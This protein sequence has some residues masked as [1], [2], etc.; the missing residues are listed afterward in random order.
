[1]AKQTKC[2]R[3]GLPKIVTAQY[4]LQDT[5]CEVTSSM[6]H[7]EQIHDRSMQIISFQKTEGV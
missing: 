1:M 3:E 7:P 2:L 5:K 4:T 6:Y